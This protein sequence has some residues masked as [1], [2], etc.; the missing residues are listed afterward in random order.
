MKIGINN[1]GYNEHRN[2]EVVW[3]SVACKVLRVNNLFKIMDFIWF[4][5]FKSTNNFFHNIIIFNF[6][7]TVQGFHFFNGIWVFSTKPWL[8]TFESVL[9]RLIGPR[10][11][12]EF[13]IKQ[14]ASENCKAIIS[15]SICN[16]TMQEQVILN[17]FPKYKD[18]LLPKLK[19]IYPSQLLPEIVNNENNDKLRILFVGTDFYRKGGHVTLRAF[20]NKFKNQNDVEL[21]VISTLDQGY[22]SDYTDENHDWVTQQLDQLDNVTW[23]KG[24]K[25]DEVLSWMKLA[26]IIM[27]PTYAETFG[28]SILEGMAHGCVPVVSN[29]RALPEIVKDTYGYVVNLPLNECYNL[30]GREN[31]HQYA[32]DLVIQIN[33]VFEDIY[34]KWRKNELKYN[35]ELGQKWIYENCNPVE[36]GKILK[37]LFNV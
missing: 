23:I 32:N 29:I 2:I 4:N 18:V 31:I 11:V 37:N 28:Y 16:L 26:D 35:K 33:D 15:M 1:S 19:K 34:E 7:N 22:L 17:E 9:P 5:F 8:V 25:N 12:K 30:K 14:L 6:F 20:V 27:L 36:K 13:L 24:A 3:E 10:F 21:I